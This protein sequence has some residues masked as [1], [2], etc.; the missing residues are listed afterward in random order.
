[1]RSVINFFI[2]GLKA[3]LKSELKVVQLTTLR[4]IFSLVKVYEA[5]GG[6][7]VHYEIWGQQPISRNLE[8]LLKNLLASKAMPIVRKTLKVEG[9][10]EC[11]T[12]GLCFN[13]DKPYVS[14]HRC[15]GKFFRM[16]IENNYL[17]KLLDE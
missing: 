15:K 3:N 6:A 13:C 2:G 4:K 9:L 8:S 10:H 14:L 11:T 7:W 16:D 17:V 12:K 1:M 5:Q